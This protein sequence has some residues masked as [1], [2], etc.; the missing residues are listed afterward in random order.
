L[1]ETTVELKEKHYIHKISRLCS[2]VFRCWSF[3]LRYIH[4]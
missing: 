1:Y 3:V 4:H 2:T